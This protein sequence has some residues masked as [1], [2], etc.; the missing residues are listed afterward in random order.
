M[1]LKDFL[2]QRAQVRWTPENRTQISRV[3]KPHFHFS[4]SLGWLTTLWFRE[5]RRNFLCKPTI[6]IDS[7]YFDILTTTDKCIEAL[8]ARWDK[9]SRIRPLSL[10]FISHF[11]NKNFKVFGLYADIVAFIL[12]DLNNFS[13]NTFGIFA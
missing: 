4:Q 6:D 2:S 9:D 13:A 5:H 7:F 11:D 12:F 8:L 1:K 3:T 10:M